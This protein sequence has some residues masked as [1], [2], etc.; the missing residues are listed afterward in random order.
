MGKALGNSFFAE[1]RHEPIAKVCFGTSCEGDGGKFPPALFR[2]RDE[3][4]SEKK[5]CNFNLS[6]VSTRVFGCQWEMHI[7][8]AL[9]LKKVRLL[10]FLGEEKNK[11]DT[12]FPSP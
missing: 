5:H 4:N 10:I 1:I 8:T 2:M 6:L 3:G 12:S 9:A 11:Y 7:T